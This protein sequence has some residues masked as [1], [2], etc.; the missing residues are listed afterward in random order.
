ILVGN[1]GFSLHWML[2]FLMLCLVGL[3]LF[4]MGILA[5]L[6]YGYAD[7]EKRW[8]IVFR[9]NVAVAISA[10][11]LMAGILSM[12]P[13][14]REYTLYNYRLPA[15][16]TAASFQA[17]AGVGMVLWSFIHFTYSMVYNAVRLSG[18]RGKAVARGNNW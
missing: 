9:F 15:G 13:L 8:Q 10:A 3:Q 7:R 5:R 16:P 6:V 2:L 17:V 14:A 11:L 1:I 18:L 4:L 12:L